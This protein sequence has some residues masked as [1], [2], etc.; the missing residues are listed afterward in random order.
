MLSPV[1]FVELHV[2]LSA[3][4]PNISYPVAPAVPITMVR[5]VIVMPMPVLE[6][7]IAKGQS[8][9]WLVIPSDQA[10]YIT[11][12]PLRASVR[13]EIPPAVVIPRR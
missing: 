11:E 10:R 4:E 6:R 13:Y 1:A 9:V 12:L 8:R 2:L 5:L 7:K 3:N